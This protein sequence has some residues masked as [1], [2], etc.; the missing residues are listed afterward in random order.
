MLTEARAL[1][2]SMIDD[3]RGPYLRIRWFCNDGTTQP[4][5][6]YACREHGGGR[7]HAEYSDQRRRLAEL[8]WSVGTIFAALDWEEL[9]DGQHRHQRLRELA[10]ERYLTDI[11]NGWVLRRARDYRGR[12]QIEGEEEAGRE[13]LLKLLQD[14][15]WI[16]ANYLLARESVRVI[17]HRGG[18]EDRTRTVRRDAI[19]LADRDSSFEHL[20]VEIHTAPSPTTARRVRSWA[21]SKPESIA[22]AGRQLADELDRLYGPSGRRER[23]EAQRVLLAAQA[24]TATL[25]GYVSFETGMS[26]RD[27]VLSL[28]QLL[29]E[30]RET[31]V[32][33][34]TP[35][36]RLLLFDVIGEVEDEL[37]V[38]VAELP[39][40]DDWS[41]A[42][43][44]ELGKSLIDATF[45][46]GLL[47][48]R[49]YGELRAV[50]RDADEP[51]L[52]LGAYGELIAY[53]RRLP[54]WAVGSVRYAFAEPLGRYTALDS[55]AAAFVDDLLRGS[56]LVGLAEITRRL[57]RDLS[58]LTGVTQSVNGR[59][60]VAA[61]GLNPG[62][63]VGA[64]QIF[65]TQ[66]ALEHGQYAR[67]DIVLLPETVAELSPVAG[68]VTLGEGSPLSHVQLLAR[69]FGIPNIAIVPNLIPLMQPL[70]GSEV[71]AAVASDGSVL[72]AS[73]E[74]LEEALRALLQPAN[75]VGGQLTVPR[76]EL[77]HREPVPLADLNA[78]LSGRVVGPKAA[79]LGELARLFPGR[80]AP[81]VAVPF[82]IFAEHLNAGA[83][84]LRARLIEAYALFRDGLRTEDELLED[85]AS[86]RRDIASLQLNA[87]RRATLIEAMRQEFGS[88]E[89][90]GLFLRS[91]TNVEDLPQFTGAGLSETLPNLVGLD[92]Q[93]AAIPQVWASV[94]SPRAIA[95]R[96]NLLTNPEEVYA[97]VLLMQSVP[98][99]KSGVM[100]TA[101]LTGH[102]AGLTV[103][104]GWGVGG[105]VAGEAV[106][107]VVLRDDGAETLVSQAKTAYQRQLNPSGGI[108]WMPA[109]DGA[110]LTADEK[111]QL[112]ALAREVQASY[113]P[114]FDEAG[115]RRPWD[116]EFG[117][118]N[119]DLKLFQIRPLVER[120]PQ[121]ADRIVRSLAPKPDTAPPAAVTLADLPRSE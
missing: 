68:I 105:A 65:E 10:L 70:R 44:L 121:L 55:R 109:A 22:E 112:R 108:R 78:S 50:W 76:P 77:S 4:P 61:F 25:S 11:D 64:L 116:I 33:P 118:V 63:A 99:D 83:P 104:T 49:E 74:R 30:A 15:D 19:E 8:G 37:A 40:L 47:T 27:R 51:T 119:G 1:V 115:R 98:S 52:S 6:A 66:D 60:G 107:T 110:V 12:V 36:S 38:T 42:R 106:E 59:T 45:G 103:S 91:D 67:T 80:V 79:N 54:Q 21:A 75:E 114:V 17:P 100:V 5:V 29:R 92:R 117:F 69:N 20:R 72:L 13:L 113:T 111:R 120:G 26:S 43:L 58:D 95:W 93:I 35:A 57:A 71:V 94:L 41:R 90:P 73:A 101:D 56:S 24:A 62:V 102:A 96:S 81:A 16:E 32:S 88:L 46:G 18:T 2:Q 84:S 85:L 14:G 9:W 39:D 23:L 53:L 86:I 82:G 3:P 31:I 34:I 7:Q 89:G 48:A 28:T 97:S 87:E